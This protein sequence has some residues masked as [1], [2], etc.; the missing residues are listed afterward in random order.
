MDKQA[1]INGL[2]SLTKT[3]IPSFMTM[4]ETPVAT[5]ALLHEITYCKTDDSL[6]FRA[7]WVLEYVVAHH[8]DQFLPIFDDFI[9]RLPEQENPS[10]Q[11]HFTKIL[12]YITDPKTAGAYRDAWEKVDRPCVVETVFGWLIDAETPVA[13]QVNCMDILFNMSREFDWITEELE[14]QI[15]FLMRGGSAAVQSRGRKLLNKL[16]KIKNAS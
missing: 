16:K 8:P 1:L 3:T 9:T 13:V 15:R 10:C 12:M 14:Q 7:A 11:R 6:A 5:V 2:T 4:D